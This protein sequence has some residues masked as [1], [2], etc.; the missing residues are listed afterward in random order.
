LVSEN[1]EGTLAVKEKLV[2]AFKQ[3]LMKKVLPKVTLEYIEESSKNPKKFLISHIQLC[4]FLLFDKV[5][6]E[7]LDYDNQE[8]SFMNNLYI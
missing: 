1:K 5:F 2:E 4:H 3:I 8:N 6:S 7:I